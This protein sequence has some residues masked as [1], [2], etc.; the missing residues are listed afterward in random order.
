VVAK[1]FPK[2][3]P[4]F[5][6]RFGTE[7]ACAEY[8]FQQ[9]W[10]GGFKCD[11]CGCPE[12]NLLPT[13]PI[14]VC[15]GCRHHHSLTSGTAL[16]GTRKGLKIWFL[17]LYFMVTS[18]QGLSAKELQRQLGLGSYE[19]AWTWLHKL[20]R[21]MVDPNR[22]TLSGI[23]EVDETWIGAPKP[24]PRGRGAAGKT[25]VACAIEKNEERLGR[26]RL[27]V[28]ADCSQEK[29]HDFVKGKLELE[30]TVHTDGW[31]GYN[32]LDRSG[33]VHMRDVVDEYEVPAHVLL[34]A[35]HRVFS[36]LK[37]WMLGTHQGAISR[38][39]LQRYLSEFEFRFNRR[40]SHSPTH[41]FQRLME[42]VVR[43]GH[44]PYDGIVGRFKT[45]S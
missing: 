6:D 40:T 29:L 5:L 34:P 4:E 14:Y 10:P 23:V 42:G 22:S 44:C 9:K 19:T 28:I 39:H 11:R 43:D 21:C 26:V 32:G 36:L 7:E 33:Y 31:R 20:R 30:S 41:L 17:A 38:K 15:Y 13:R 37:R 35:V 45:A 8:L 12:A 3:L 1:D 24:G 25:V 27:A 2:S 18:K 16:H